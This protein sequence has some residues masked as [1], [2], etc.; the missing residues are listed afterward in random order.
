MKNA[1]VAPRDVWGHGKPM[2]H[3]DMPAVSRV[4]EPS[5]TH[6]KPE[7]DTTHF[8]LRKIAGCNRENNWE[9]IELTKKG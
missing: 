7:G 8:Y 1:A 5:F 3:A 2:C 6:F 9:R 4:R